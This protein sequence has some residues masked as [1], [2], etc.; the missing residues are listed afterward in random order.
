MAKQ[1]IIRASEAGVQ[2][3][4]VVHQ[5]SKRVFSRYVVSTLRRHSR[6]DF[7]SLRTARVAF[8][9]EVAASRRLTDGEEPRLPVHSRTDRPLTSGAPESG[10][11]D[12]QP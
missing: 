1:E 12:G 10:G 2:L 7:V 4:E 11:L 5:M 8:D 9:E 6:R 3:V